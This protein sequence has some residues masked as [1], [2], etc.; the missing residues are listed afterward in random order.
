MN[1]Y[2][3]NNQRLENTYRVLQDNTHHSSVLQCVELSITMSNYMSGSNGGN[4]AKPPPNNYKN[5][6][7]LSNIDLDRLKITIVL[8]GLQ[9]WVIIGTPMMARLKWYLHPLPSSSKKNPQKTNKKKRC[10]SLTPSDE[11]FWI[12]EYISSTIVCTVEDIED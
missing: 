2:L 4:G 5:I 1:I 6:G 3:L 7:F 11:T 10:P 12:H 9:C 8:V